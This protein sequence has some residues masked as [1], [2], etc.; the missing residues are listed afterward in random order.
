MQ[1]LWG[2]Q[3]RIL[4]QGCILVLE[5]QLVLTTVNHV[6]QMWEQK[7]NSEGQITLAA[8]LDSLEGLILECQQRAVSLLSKSTTESVLHSTYFAWSPLFSGMFQEFGDTLMRSLVALRTAIHSGS[9]SRQSG[10]LG[11]CSMSTILE[12]KQRLRRSPR[13]LNKKS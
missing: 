8:H 3:A 7:I 4:S 12:N 10:A 1:L 5:F 9:Y 11:S 13:P 6:I 2:P